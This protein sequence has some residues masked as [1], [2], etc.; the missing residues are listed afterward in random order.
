MLEILK[1][2]LFLS[3][4]NLLQ[5]EIAK[6]FYNFLPPYGF[7]LKKYCNF[8]RYYND[9]ELITAGTAKSRL[10][11]LKT[12]PTWFKTSVDQNV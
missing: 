9:L 3:H 5:T 8:E 11:Q 10:E 1:K 7:S 4:K 12:G 6:V 2:I